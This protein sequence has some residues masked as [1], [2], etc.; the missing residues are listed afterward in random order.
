MAR[1]YGDMIDLQVAV[2]YFAA[3]KQQARDSD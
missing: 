3:L 1:K 2:D